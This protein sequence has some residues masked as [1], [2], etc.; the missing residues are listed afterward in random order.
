[1]LSVATPTDPGLTIGLTGQRVLNIKR[2]NRMMT[3]NRGKFLKDGR[4]VPLEF[5]NAEQINLLKKA[6]ALAE[7]VL[8]IDR[9]HCLCGYVFTSF[10]NTDLDLVKII[11]C[12]TCSLRYKV[13]TEEGIMV[14]TL[15]K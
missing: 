5:G 10:R 7:G 15:K 8:C 11:K 14:I 13:D 9:F 6:E 4:P 1:V 2:G 3:L 12:P